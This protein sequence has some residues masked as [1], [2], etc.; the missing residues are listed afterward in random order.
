[1]LRLECIRF[2]GS[3]LR[4]RA[5]EA[6]AGSIPQRF[7][8]GVEAIICV[9]KFLL[10]FCAFCSSIC[11]PRS[12]SSLRLV[13]VGIVCVPMLA[14]GHGG[15]AGVRM[16]VLVMAMMGMMVAVVVGMVVVAVVLS[17]RSGRATARAA[18]FQVLPQSPLSVLDR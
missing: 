10:K 8:L 3:D 7:H 1:M 11:H 18:W 15:D 2:L 5:S 17:V 14:D 16:V 9:L 4:I 13:I 6:S 12:L